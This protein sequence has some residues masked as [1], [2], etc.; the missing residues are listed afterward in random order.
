MKNPNI[1]LVY[2]PGW[3]SISPPLGISCIKS[4]LDKDGFNVKCLDFSV[5][6]DGKFFDGATDKLNNYVEKI[7]NQNPDAIGLS[8]LD[9]NF[10]HS[11]YIA[12]RI[13]QESDDLKVIVGG[14]QVSYVGKE[15]LEN[16]SFVDIA[17][18]GEGEY[19][20]LDIMEDDKYMKL[21]SSRTVLESPEIEDL[22]ILPFPDF[23][24]FNLKKYPV[25]ILPLYTNRG[26]T[27]NCT[28]CGMQGN[29]VFGSYRER[30]PSQVVEEIK[31]DIKRYDVSNFLITDA[32]VNANPTLLENICDLIIESNIEI[33]WAAEAFSNIRKETLTKMHDSGC[34]FLW[35][36]PE[37]GSPKIT[38][39]MKKGVNLKHAEKTIKEAGKM[40]IYISTWFILG[41]P[42]ETDRDIELTIKF[43]KKIKEFSKEVCF[44]PFTLMKGSYIYNNPIEFG[45][46]KIER[47]CCDIWCSFEGENL[48]PELKAVQRTISLW[49]DFNDIGLSYPFLEEYSREEI[50]YIIG[51]LKP[52]EREAFEKDVRETEKKERYSYS[53]IFKDVF[54]E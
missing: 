49:E 36:S 30:K 5:E 33:K 40:G 35:L 50:Q 39:K 32:L 53:K 8:L 16:Y 22:N 48:I 18:S 1:I 9:P 25:P 31:H 19:G 54:S 46:N 28:F 45:I 47:D 20:F 6:L 41:F 2:P 15:I 43:A 17:I 29:R 4:F 13:K 26:C 14:P 34:R 42:G 12:E 44:V 52:E 38:K 23:D 7:L 37:S 10:K 3:D 51:S 21:K 11:M 27:K 24:D